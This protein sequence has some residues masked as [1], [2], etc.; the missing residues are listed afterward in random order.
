LGASERLTFDIPVPIREQA[1]SINLEYRL[2][3]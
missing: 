3:P 1:A 2:T